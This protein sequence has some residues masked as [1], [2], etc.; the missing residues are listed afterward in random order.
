M[1]ID[2]LSFNAK[3]TP[4]NL[5]LI[6]EILGHFYISEYRNIGKGF[7][8]SGGLISL[9]DSAGKIEVVLS[10]KALS[11]YRFDDIRKLIF[12]E[13]FK[14]SRLDIAYDDRK[15]FLKIDTIEKY[16]NNRERIISTFKNFQRLKSNSFHKKRTLPGDT[17]YMGN[18]KSHTFIRIYNKLMESMR[19]KKGE[20][21]S[22]LKK[23][24]KDLK[25]NPH[26]IRVEIELK[27]RNADFAF[28]K[29]IEENFDFKTFLYRTVDFKRLTKN[30]SGNL[31]RRDRRKTAKFWLNF[32]GSIEKEKLSLP[33]KFWSL[34]TLDN[35]F[36]NQ[37]SPS[38]FAL[39]DTFGEKDFLRKIKSAK[40]RF[41][42]SGI[43]SKY[44]Q[45]DKIIKFVN[46]AKRIL[47]N[48]HTKR[49]N[50]L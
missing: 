24:F 43:K 39:Y 21:I 48:G 42:K 27:Q 37:I 40:E 47:R 10:S 9:I 31:I 32:L 28:K 25:V 45:R 34:E 8:P 50:R 7:F 33:L 23:R 22:T 3:K 29:I 19:I 35:W 41:L 20:K 15:G 49:T 2:W 13:N 46:S 1:L 11:F 4:A 44:S 16:A 17:F 18:R 5:G 12:L 30:K 6:K 38:A 14:V 26:W 36:M